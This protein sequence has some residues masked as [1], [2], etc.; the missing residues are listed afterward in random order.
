MN[1]KGY[2]DGISV[3]VPVYNAEAYLCQCI[4]SILHQSFSEFE[5]ILIDDGATDNS[6]KLCDE[7]A[8]KD[9][10][11]RVFHRKN[12]GVSA[13]RNA[14]MD[15]AVYKYLMFVDSDDYIDTNMFAEMYAQAVNSSANCV[16][17]GLQYVFEATGQKRD[18]ILENVVFSV[19]SEMN[20]YYSM[21]TDAYGLNCVWAKLFSTQI[22][23]DN[24]L[25]FSREISILED[26]AFV[27]LYMQH[28]DKCACMAD[29]FY[30]YRQ[31]ENLSLMKRFNRNAIDALTYKHEMDCFLLEKLD[32]D[33]TSKYYRAQYSLLRSFSAQIYTRSMCD[34]RNKKA[35]LQHYLNQNVA[36]TIVSNNKL[37][38]YRGK[39]FVILLLMKLRC[40]SMLHWLMLAHFSK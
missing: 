2:L 6:G 26:G 9:P 22:L 20:R 37:W 12:A 10:R 18:F 4:E 21:I 24:K 27:S 28:C 39:K 40:T 15:V 7:Y 36:K 30:H 25:Y 1:L 38:D 31:S 23:Q 14:G 32:V 19:N 34:A 8:T 16:M 11:V 13:A 3:V 17:S 35:L 5:L 29:V 33:N